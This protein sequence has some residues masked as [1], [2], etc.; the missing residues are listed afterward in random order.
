M[1][2]AYRR[3]IAPDLGAIDQMN[4]FQQYA[5][6]VLAAG[7]I[8]TAGF[9]TAALAAAD[10]AGPGGPPQ[11]PPMNGRMD[12]PPLDGAEFAKRAEAHRA[13]LHA[14]LKLS[15]DQESA[16]STFVEK[17]K[18]EARHARPDW[19]EISKLSTPDRLDKELSFA[20][21]GL[22]RLSARAATIKT[23]YAKLTPDQQKTF[24]AEFGPKHHRGGHGPR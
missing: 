8:S 4:K 10:S 1:L 3:E 19:A 11:G 18:P 6:A 21:E 12:R 14:D 7:A 13:K 22:N 2:L 24:D 15:A 16:W 9:Q 20:R 5:M 17:T 23:F